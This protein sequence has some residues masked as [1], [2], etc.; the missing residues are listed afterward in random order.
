[1][2]L[3]VGLDA[4]AANY[5]TFQS[6]A[7]GAEVAGV[8]KADAYGC[9]VA[10]TVP[11]LTNM[12]CRTF[13]VAHLDEGIALRQHVRHGAIYV[14]NGLLP[15]TEAVYST[16]HLR[17]VITSQHQLYAWSRCCRKNGWRGGAALHIDTGMN[18][19]GFRLEEVAGIAELSVSDLACF[20]LVLSHLACGDEPENPR[21]AEQLARFTWARRLLSCVPRASLAAS[22]GCYLGVQA[23]FDLVRPGIGLF[24]GN[25]FATRRNPLQ[26]VLRAS[27]PLLQVK[28]HA[29]GDFVGYGCDCRLDRDTLIGAVSLGYADGLPRSASSAPVTLYYGGL[30]IR[31]MGRI[32]MDMT[33]VDLTSVRHLEPRVGTQV[34]IFGSSR[35]LNHFA[36]SIGTIANEVLTSLGRRARRVYEHPLSCPIHDNNPAVPVAQAS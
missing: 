9:G 30:P 2:T 4:L 27:A 34:E 33:L 26:P 28:R 20:D 3:T 32:S 11:T 10:G 24:G 8:V 35:D 29:A 15:G 13:F 16:Y 22:A 5:R 23:H 25:P 1:M 36:G 14:L 6:V 17:P 12:G 7:C 19:L 31:A 18:R 21:N